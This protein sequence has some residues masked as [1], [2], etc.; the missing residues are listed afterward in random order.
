MATVVVDTCVV[1]FLH[2]N[3]TRAQLYQGH[4]GGNLKVISFM[5]LAELYRWALESNWG[6]RQK[7]KLE[8]RLRDYVVYSVT[9]P[10]CQQWAAITAEASSKGTPIDVDDAWIAATALLYDLPLVTHNRKHYE[11]IPGL[12]VVSESP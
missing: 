11:V 5:T 6:E 10:L 8:E 7:A 3:D 1:S 2:K 4:L 9:R 12:E